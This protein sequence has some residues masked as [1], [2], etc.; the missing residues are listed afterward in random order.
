MGLYL[1]SVVVAAIVL[2][3]KGDYCL[4]EQKWRGSGFCSSLGV[5]FSFSS[6]GSLMVVACVSVVRC[7]TCTA[8]LGT[9][10][11]KTSVFFASGIMFLTNLVHSIFPLLPFAIIQD[12]FRTEIFFTNVDE[13][14]FFNKNPVNFSHLEKIYRSKY[15]KEGSIHTAL[16][17]LRNVTSKPEMFDTM[18][19]GYYGNTGLC[20]NNIFK[21]QDSYKA[22]KLSYCIS[23]VVLLTIVIFTYFRIVRADRK[24]KA[25]LAA[26]ATGEK[27]NAQDNNSNALTL[28]VALMIGTQIIGW[29]PLIVTTVYFQYMSD[30]H[31]P[32]LIFEVFALVVIPINSFLNPV[33]N[34]ELYKKVIGFLWGGWK[35]LV[36][37]VTTC[38]SEVQAANDEENPES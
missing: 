27:N 23:L 31:V 9:E 33:F 15:Q 35:W 5:L 24:S 17:G 25:R 37:R 19:I 2:R 32:P 29:I 11:K 13:N 26:A 38:S 21:V 14:P 10:V 4:I 34:S 30:N 22:Y 36:H 8:S 1:C 6:H 12:F 3:F 16:F 28:K 18:E 20:V 7:I